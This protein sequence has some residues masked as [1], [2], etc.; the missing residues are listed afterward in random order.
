MSHEELLSSEWVAD[1]TL[2]AK[3]NVLVRPKVDF[4][5]TEFK[6]AVVTVPS[7]NNNE[8]LLQLFESGVNSDVVFVIQGEE[9][10]AHSV[11]LSAFSEV[12]QRQ[13][14]CGMEETTSKRVVIE[15]CEPTTFKA[16]LRYLYSSDFAHLG[17]TK[18]ET[19]STGT[20]SDHNR[21]TSSSSK[22]IHSERM[23]FL[24]QVLALSHKY[25]ETRLLR[26]TERELSE[27]ITI[28]DV[29]PVLCQAH[30]YE[31]KVLEE[32]CLAFIVANKNA[33]AKSDA[34]GTL[35]HE[36]PQVNLKIALRLAG[37]SDDS[38]AIAMKNHENARKR[39][40][41]D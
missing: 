20:G 15:D 31:A 39:K 1:D 21:D 41:S 5:E 8:K 3:L 2:T 11:I 29:C 19:T 6:D 40:R 37:V 27:H 22:S 23:N 33:V 34:F 30:L 24:R 17:I 38:T 25:Q 10:K 32:K 16:F 36:W 9:V 12:F 13:F 14:A 7:S 35:S 26:W 4:I 18:A 28:E